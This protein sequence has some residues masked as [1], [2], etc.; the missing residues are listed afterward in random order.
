MGRHSTW[1][2]LL[3]DELD[4]SGIAPDEQLRETDRAVSPATCLRLRTKTLACVTIETRKLSATQRESLNRIDA[5]ILVMQQHDLMLSTGGDRRPAWQALRD[6]RVLHLRGVRLGEPK[7]HAF[8]ETKRA[9]APACIRG[10]PR[11]IRTHKI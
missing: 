3:R 7:A 6:S 4:R 5:E 11:V 2:P 10:R 8:G 1:Q 9:V